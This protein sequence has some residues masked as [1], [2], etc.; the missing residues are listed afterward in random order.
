MKF[1]TTAKEIRDN[2]YTVIG[3][4]YC[5]AQNL[6]KCSE[7]IAYSAGV[8]GWNCDYYIIDNVVICTGYRGIINKN[9][10]S[11][12]NIVRDYDNKAEKILHDY[13]IDYEARKI[14][15]DNLLHEFIITVKD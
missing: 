3:I 12:Y 11:N 14:K 5:E 15:L 6:L 10:H 8:Y 4:G 13:S 2:Y 7:P 1:K 9:N